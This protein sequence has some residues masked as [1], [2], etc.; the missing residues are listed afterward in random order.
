MS[1]NP[2]WSE[3]ELILALDLYCS[4]FPDT[5]PDGSNPHVIELSD[6]LRR[7]GVAIYGQENIST[8][9]RSPDSVA[10]RFRNY[11]EIDPNR[12]SGLS[13]STGEKVT[14]VF[15]TYS[16]DTELLGKIASNIRGLLDK[17]LVEI[18][19]S[20]D[21]LEEMAPEGGLVLR[22]HRVYERKSSN[23]KKKLKQF[24]D[25]NK[26]LFC[27]V[28]FIET[29]KE[30]GLE[31]GGTILECHHLTPLS[32]ISKAKRYK[33]SEIALL[34]PTC[35]RAIHRLDDCSNIDELKKRFNR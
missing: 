13:G 30:Y 31:I 4:R 18:P 17:P 26:K 24:F 25:K 22:T 15:N 16:N 7:L 23:R 10:M 12:D 9:Y 27:E 35:H 8:D 14:R 5:Q 20:P 6:T 33:Y 19:T 11:S 28:C 21:E 32:E 3:E 29:E 1:Q 34:C 2:D